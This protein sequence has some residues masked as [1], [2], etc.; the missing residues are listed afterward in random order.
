MTLR[1][2]QVLQGRSLGC[3]TLRVFYGFLRCGVCMQ[4]ACPYNEDDSVTVPG[5]KCE[6]GLFKVFMVEVFFLN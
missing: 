2:Y 3:P 5:T 1:T 6:E 4:A